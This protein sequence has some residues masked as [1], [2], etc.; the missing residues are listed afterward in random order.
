MIPTTRNG[1]FD[2]TFNAFGMPEKW[3]TNISASWEQSRIKKQ[4]TLIKIR[5]WERKTEGK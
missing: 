3:K 4:A 1:K 5:F 2:I